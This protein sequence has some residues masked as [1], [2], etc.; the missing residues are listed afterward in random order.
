MTCHPYGNSMT[1][2]QDELSFHP[3]FLRCL[4]SQVK[5]VGLTGRDTTTGTALDSLKLPKLEGRFFLSVS[6]TSSMVIELGITMVCSNCKHS[7]D[8]CIDI[9]SLQNRLLRVV[10]CPPL[11][12]VLVGFFFLLRPLTV[13]MIHE[14]NKAGSM[15]H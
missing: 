6:G 9:E 12:P 7:V 15:Q 3:I 8:K 10:V 13:L 5:W 14:A 1:C 2:C 4:C 11:A